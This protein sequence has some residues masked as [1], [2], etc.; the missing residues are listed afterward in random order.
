[1]LTADVMSTVFLHVGQCGNQLGHT[2]WQEVDE[3][4]SSPN[5]GV[6]SS[7]PIG[8]HKPSSKI[9]NKFSATASSGC[10]AR[11]CSH[12]HTPYSLLDGTLPCVLVDTETK[13]IR[14]CTGEKTLLGKRIPGE[15]RV[16]E[17]GGRGNNWAYGFF[18]AKENRAERG[19]KVKMFTLTEPETLVNKVQ[20]CVRRL[21]E[22]CDRLGGF[23]QL[24]SIAGGTGSGEM[25]SAIHFYLL[26]TFL[27][28]C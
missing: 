28:K 25:F 26:H 16:V 9:S 1:M 20:E 17:R 21:A 18:S 23:V 2:F 22:K 10:T 8:R 7:I 4:Y 11:T 6:V 19:G 24:H 14:K 5:P 13:V 3:W 12:P 27:L 15:F